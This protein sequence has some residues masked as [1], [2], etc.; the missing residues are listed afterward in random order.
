M[1]QNA[2]V[3][4]LTDELIQSILRFDPKEN[5][6]AYR[7]AKDIATKGLRPH[8]YNRTNQFDVQTSFDGLDEK[9]RVL[10]RDD[11]ADALGSRVKALQAIEGK[12][13]RWTP[14]YLS[15]LLQLSDRPVENSSVEALELLRPPTPPL[16]LTWAEII[17]DDPLTDEELW[18]D[19][20][21]AADSS[22]DEVSP[23]KKE[24]ARAS[25]PTSVDEDDTYDPESCVLSDDTKPLDEI[26]GVQF[27]IKEAEEE[28][29]KIEITELQAV[30]ETL[31]MLA[32]LQTSL[33]L[34]NRQ[35]ASIRVNHTYT[36]GH[37]MDRT[38]DHLLSELAD[39]GREL[40]RLRQWSRKPSSL[41]LIQ[42]FEAAVRSRLAHFDRNLA[43][44]QQQY[45][46]PDKPIAVSLLRIHDEVQATSEPL[47]R[48]S[49]LVADI[50]PHLLVNPFAHLE[51]L[52]DHISIA[53]MT[54]EKSIFDFFANIFF[55]CLQT[56]LKPI[57]RWMESGELGS[58]DETFFI[59]ENDSATE[60]ASLWHDRYV[61][62][63]GQGNQLR[64]P[65]FLQP[66]VQKIFNT[67]KSVVFLKGLG[68]YGSGLR[69]SDP[70]PNLDFDTVCGTDAEV[71]FSPFSEL[72]A[73][74]FDIWI[75]SKYSL[76]ST[77]L[78]QHLFSQHGLLR[79]L[80]DFKIIYLSA[81]GTVFQD[82]ASALF[83]RLD[84]VPRGWNDRFLLTELLRGVYSPILST[85]TVNSLVIRSSRTK[86]TSKSV[87]QL[88][89]VAIDIFLPWPLQN[90]IQR[91][92]LPAYQQ[93]FT[94]LLQIYRSQYLVQNIGLRTLGGS[95]VALKLRQRLL[96]LTDILRSYLT[97]IVIELCMRE[98]LEQMQKAED[99]DEMSSVHL[100]YIAR[101]QEQ[102]LLSDNL[103]PIHKAVIQL[104]D[105]GVLFASTVDKEADA[106]G[107]SKESGKKKGGRRKSV[108][109]TVVDDSDS[110]A[111]DS[112]GDE[113]ILSTKKDSPKAGK[114]ETLKHI[115][116]QFASLLSFV[117]AGLRSVGRVGAE[118]IW[119][120]LA[121]RL[122]WDK[123]RERGYVGI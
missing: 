4:A 106:A 89:G 2:R 102:A 23:K 55:D 51:S 12:C 44:L 79:T 84:T 32:G 99:I 30:R 52:Y 73:S 83:T 10:N 114:A 13:A 76:A 103:K 91:S 90:I 20:D 46:V 40:Y 92:S 60:A 67:G 121:E 64:S 71:P 100:K 108:M 78:R 86:I 31:H 81:N 15:L 112:D 77:I 80:Q 41:P 57:R 87:K 65:S 25:P 33:Y 66:A 45:L 105:L 95:H 69:P 75:R 16:P 53:Q 26:N 68:I 74:A 1:A 42:T 29:A 62:R 118:P 117:T 5:K 54:L 7:H 56:Y 43:V 21:Y 48:L 37:A 39:I 17:A 109:P 58:N 27:W 116:E 115:D 34:S 8:Q 122:E 113:E 94:L 96:W 47:R 82:F 93:L 61:L 59:F 49:Q 63:R 120:M 28:G 3:A 72:F 101:M 24:K 85:S 110:S 119:E 35:N 19:I 123:P 88:S 38:V 97:E 18:K 111:S 98:M 50:E 70:E 9:F 22:E 36:L 6:Q 107:G 14:E 104:L 11:L